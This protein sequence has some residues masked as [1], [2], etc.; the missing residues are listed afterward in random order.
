MDIPGYEPKWRGLLTYTRCKAEAM[1]YSDEGK[2]VIGDLPGHAW[3]KLD[4]KE[5]VTLDDIRRQIRFRPMWAHALRV[6]DIIEEKASGDL[7]YAD[8]LDQW[9]QCQ[10]C[11]TVWLRDEVMEPLRHTPAMK[12]V[13]ASINRETADSLTNWHN[14]WMPLD[15]AIYNARR[16]IDLEG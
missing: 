1:R 6:I 4:M 9:L 11:S 7:Y 15:T 3:E 13:T 8:I 16:G 2:N 14:T 10:A 12:E 5:A